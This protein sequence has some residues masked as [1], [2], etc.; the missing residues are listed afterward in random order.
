L[1]TAFGQSSVIAQ[2]SVMQKDFG[3]YW[4]TRMEPPVPPMANALGYASGTNPKNNIY[5]VM[6]DRSQR[7]Y[8]GY[9]VHIEALPQR[10]QY[11][12]AF[13]RLD[14][15]PETLKRIHIDDPERWKQLELGAPNPRPL[16]PFREAPDTVQALDV[17]A[18]DLLV[19]QQTGQRIVDY[20]VLQGPSQTW[21]FDRFS[22]PQQR[23]FSYTPGTARDFSVGDVNLTLTEPRVSIN[24]KVDDA[25]TH[26]LGEI[27]G[28]AVWFYIPTMGATFCR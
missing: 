18:V 20:V 8:F 26:S 3:F 15:D 4:Q 10:N 13:E 23:E 16:Y 2:G 24:G 7:T 25:T 17:I 14:L 21:S 22:P 12:V 11:R 6:M 1:G 5:R 27:G 19:N 28:T 9:E